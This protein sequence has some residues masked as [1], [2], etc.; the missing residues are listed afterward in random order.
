MAGRLLVDLD[1]LAAN[2]RT[3]VDATHQPAMHRRTGPGSETR[4]VGAVVKANAY[5]LGVGPVSRRLI[6]EGCRSFFV[7]TALEGAQLRR[8]LDEFDG[9]RDVPVSIYVFEGVC[10][11]SEAMLVDAE[12]IPVVNHAAQLARWRDLKHLPIAVHVDSGMG[13]LGFADDLAPALLEGF[14]LCLL[15]T[16]LACADQH[17]HP[18]T[19]RQLQRFADVCKRFPG[20]R[21]SIGNSAG[22][23]GGE[24]TQGGLGRPGIGLYGGNPFI[25]SQNPVSRVVRFEGSVLQVRHLGAGES[26]GYGASV[27]TESPVDIATIGIGYADGFPRV[28]SNRGEMALNGRRCR[29]IGRI[30]MDTTM[31]DLTEYLRC[32]GDKPAEGDWVECFGRHISLDEVAALAD[33]VSYEMLTGI[34]SRVTRQYLPVS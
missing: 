18:H 11:G 20:V 16:H 13:R 23:L 26:I 32:G 3:L 21:T 33:T 14:Q 25:D 2:Y 8:L 24:S 31:I 15:M 22:W 30:S 5:G 27:V 10:A 17:D 6:Q 29:V 12:L 4:E 9:A 1:A 7:A 34:G 28:L 19:E